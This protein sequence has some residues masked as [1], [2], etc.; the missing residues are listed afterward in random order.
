M[1]A[2]LVWKIPFSTDPKRPKA[3][4]IPE[5]QKPALVYTLCGHPA[6]PALARNRGSARYCGRCMFLSQ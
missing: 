4:L 1:L 3:H 5:G 2:G 6:N